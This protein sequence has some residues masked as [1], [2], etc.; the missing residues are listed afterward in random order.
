M[1]FNQIFALLFMLM[2][3]FWS[4]N[5]DFRGGGGGFFTF[6]RQ[7]RDTVFVNKIILRNLSALGTTNSL[8]FFF[9][10]FLFDFVDLIK[11]LI[12]IT[13]WPFLGSKRGFLI[14]KLGS[15]TA[16]LKDFRYVIFLGKLKITI[17]L[18]GYLFVFSVRC[19]KYE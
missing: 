7:K 13:C 8:E 5:W 1:I 11:S 2:A 17:L 14:L 6:L 18:L 15:K 16:I 12:F 3:N 4:P 9:N 10:A 19:Q